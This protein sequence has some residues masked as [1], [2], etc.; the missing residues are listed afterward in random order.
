MNT[1]RGTRRRRMN[2]HRNHCP[3]RRCFLHEWC[4]QRCLQHCRHHG[5]HGLWEVAHSSAVYMHFPSR[6]FQHTLEGPL[7][8]LLK[9]FEGYLRVVPPRPK[10][11]LSPRASLLLPP[12]APPLEVFLHSSDCA[13]FLTTERTFPSSGITGGGK[14]ATEVGGVTSSNDCTT[15][16]CM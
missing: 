10:S 6:N 9:N 16:F 14:S 8:L 13:P 4:R 1:F 5:Q 15:H 7:L 2:L 12:E 3:R 11:P